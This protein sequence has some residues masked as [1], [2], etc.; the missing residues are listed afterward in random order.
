MKHLAKIFLFGF[1]ASMNAQHQFDSL[2]VERSLILLPKT[3]IQNN[4]DENLIKAI[5]AVDRSY[6]KIADTLYSFKSLK[7]TIFQTVAIKT[8]TNY[9][10]PLDCGDKLQTSS[11]IFYNESLNS[12]ILTTV[13]NLNE[14]DLQKFYKFLSNNF[15]HFSLK[16]KL[17]FSQSVRIKYIKFPNSEIAKVG[18]DIY[19]AHFL[20]TIDRTKNWNVVKVER[21]W[22]Y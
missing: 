19:G 13:E 18:I 11:I 9:F 1:F 15:D 2:S 17:L 4:C 12:K 10:N 16:E 3:E 8:D 22:T 7:H 5:E 6:R 21:L 14:K 20:W